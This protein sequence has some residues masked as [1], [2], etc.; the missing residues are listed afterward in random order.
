MWLTYPLIKTQKL[1]T[2]LCSKMLRD[3]G[4]EKGQKQNVFYLELYNVCTSTVM[5]EVSTDEPVCFRL[6][7]K[8]TNSGLDTDSLS[9][10]KLSL[11]SCIPANWAL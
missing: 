5:G 9:G 3:I 8:H 2:I 11:C 7:C 6:I 1:V 4:M 10:L